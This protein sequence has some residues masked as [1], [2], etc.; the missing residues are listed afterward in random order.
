MTNNNNQHKKCV[1][2]GTRKKVSLPYGS[3]R[4]PSYSTMGN[5]LLRTSNMMIVAE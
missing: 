1:E 2:K 5:W 3:Y 4:A